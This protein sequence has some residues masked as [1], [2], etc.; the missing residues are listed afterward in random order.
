M[1]GLKERMW[2]DM[3]VPSDL[4]QYNQRIVLRWLLEAIPT[5]QLPN[6]KKYVI[7]KYIT[8]ILVI[9]GHP[10]CFPTYANMRCI[11]VYS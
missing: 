1:N 11:H 9:Y 6:N 7:F 5:T 3:I 4:L 10:Y 8:C 2:I